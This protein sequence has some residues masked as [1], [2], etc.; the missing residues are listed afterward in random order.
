MIFLETEHTFF[1][2]ALILHGSPKPF[3]AYSLPEPLDSLTS[4]LS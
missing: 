4:N 1:L 2:W 3:K